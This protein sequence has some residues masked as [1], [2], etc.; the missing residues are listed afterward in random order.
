MLFMPHSI[1]WRK[2]DFRMPSILS[3]RGLN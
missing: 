3:P 1:E 2:N